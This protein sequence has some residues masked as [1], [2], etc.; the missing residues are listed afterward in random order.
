MALRAGCNPGCTG[1]GGGGDCDE[2]I[3]GCLCP[4]TNVPLACTED[5]QL[6]LMFSSDAGNIAQLG[7]DQGLFVPSDGTPPPPTGRKTIA[8]LPAQFF[9]GFGTGN[10]MTPMGSPAGVEHCVAKG[11]DWIDNAVATTLDGTSMFTPYSSSNAISAY[12]TNTSTNTMGQISTAEARGLFVDAGNPYQPMSQNQD[13]AAPD[14]DPVNRDEN[15]YGWKSA[16]WTLPTTAEMLE[17]VNARAVVYLNCGLATD[18]APA[19]SAVAIAR[20]QTWCIVGVTVASLSSASTVTAAGMTAGLFL[21]TDTTLT[22]AAIV[23]A[24]VTWVIA[25]YTQTDARLNALAA[26][27][28]NVVVLT[29]S[30]HRQ[31]GRVRTTLV[32]MRGV[33]CGDPVYA[34]GQ[35]GTAAALSYRRSTLE[36]SSKGLHYGGLTRKTANFQVLDGRGYTTNAENG[37]NLEPQYQWIDGSTPVGYAGNNLWELMPLATPAAYT[38]EYYAMIRGAQPTSNACKFGVLFGFADDRDIAVQNITVAQ[39]GVNGYWAFIRPGN[40]SLS[41][42]LVIGKITDGIYSELAVSSVRQN[43]GLNSFGRFTLAVT[44]TGITFTRYRTADQY[45]VTTTDTS[46]RGPYA[47]ESKD[48]AVGAGGSFN[49][50]LDRWTVT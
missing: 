45:S 44:G 15:W 22:P 31:T 16:T 32:G 46:F 50:L 7:T 6:G 23:A 5:G 3:V 42:Q 21:D 34:R 49:L 18:V 36:W 2:F 30:T 27:G 12:S 13:I 47:K 17:R 14:T 35:L 37:H 43:W 33:T 39:P 29:D 26:A 38:I 4:N 1:G 19:V 40:G 8:G 9:G 25:R 41:G 20:A 10:L 11:I 48:E 28:L 24:G